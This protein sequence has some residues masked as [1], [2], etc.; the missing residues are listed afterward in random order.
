M[1][2]AVDEFTA[3]KEQTAIDDRNKLVI[4]FFTVL[5]SHFNPK[6]AIQAITELAINIVN[7]SPEIKQSLK[8]AI[9]DKQGYVC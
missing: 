5:L 4:P 1:L 8:E 7:N 2:L 3:P 9:K 6:D